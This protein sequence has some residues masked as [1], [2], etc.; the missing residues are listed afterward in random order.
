MNPDEM[1]NL[2]AEAMIGEPGVTRAKMF[3]SPG[4]RI[5]RKFFGC[6]HNGKLTI[7]LPQSRVQAVIGSGDGDPFDPGMGRTMKEW[8]AV[9]PGSKADWLTLA[10]EARDFV[11]STDS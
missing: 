9:A 6:L 10:Q 7:K 2:V 8:V 4:L 5:G 11:A 3:G 1:F